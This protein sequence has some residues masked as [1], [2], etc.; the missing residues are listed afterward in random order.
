MCSRTTASRSL[1][2]ELRGTL[3]KECEYAFLQVLGGC[4]A[5]ERGILTSESFVERFFSAANDRLQD[6]CD[7]D[8]RFGRKGGSE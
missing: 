1:T 7:G 5:L 6:A 3:L 4:H 2:F 8:G